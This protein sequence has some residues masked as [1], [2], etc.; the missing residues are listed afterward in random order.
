MMATVL[1]MDLV[2]SGRHSAGQHTYIRW[3]NSASKVFAS[4][5][6]ETLVENLITDLPSI[7]RSVIITF[8]SGKAS[9][10]SSEK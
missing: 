6:L 2:Q 10:R 1:D 8:A 3:E 4:I 9:I 7:G 5:V